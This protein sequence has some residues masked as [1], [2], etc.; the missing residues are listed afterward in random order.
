MPVAVLLPAV[1]VM[2][3]VTVLMA[4]DVIL[5]AKVF[6][7]IA[8]PERRHGAVI[9]ALGANLHLAILDCFAH[10]IYGSLIVI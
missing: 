4:T 8:A 10:L 6:A 3:A 5:R 1:A 9:V 2:M 7:A